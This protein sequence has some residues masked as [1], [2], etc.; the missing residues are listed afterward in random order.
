MFAYYT[1]SGVRITLGPVDVDKECGIDD[2]ATFSC[3]YEGTTSIPQ[4]IINSTRYSYRS[5][6]PEHV[7]NSLAYEL[8]VTNIRHKNLTT[9]QC[10][11]VRHERGSPCAYRSTVGRLII[12]C[13][14][15]S[16]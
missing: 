6:P 2:F 10:Q 16:I 3:E 14:G 1:H 11:F 15:N 7:Y 13:E 4:W 5:L 9:Y 8:S 12:R